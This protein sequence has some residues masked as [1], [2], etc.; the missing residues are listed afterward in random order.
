MVHIPSSILHSDCWL[1][2]YL[3]V[4]VRL[5]LKANLRQTD[6][7]Q[8]P[9]KWFQ[10]SG[11]RKE[12]E[13]RQEGNT[14]WW[15]PARLLLGCQFGEDE[16]SKV[17]HRVTLQVC[18]ARR[19]VMGFLSSLHHP[20]GASN[21]SLFWPVPLREG[22]GEVCTPSRGTSSGRTIHRVMAA[23]KGSNG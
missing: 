5:S 7:G 8:L 10:E 22:W 2:C 13:W 6:T 12:G 21:T 20:L 14:G 15:A 23:A 16:I 1:C 3:S 9:R 17:K 18:L 4:L 19:G 11:M